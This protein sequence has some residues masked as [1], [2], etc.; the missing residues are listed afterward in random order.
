MGQVA[1]QVARLGGG[2]KYRWP[3]IWV[4]T[5]PIAPATCHGEDAHCSKNQTYTMLAK[6]RSDG[7]T[8]GGVTR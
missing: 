5:R 7:T 4:K 1:E 8:E 6:A 2:A 3:G